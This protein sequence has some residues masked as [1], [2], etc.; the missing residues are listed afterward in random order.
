M[1]EGAAAKDAAVAKA[2]E[3]GAQRAEAAVAKAVDEAREEKTAAVAKVRC[4]ALPARSSQARVQAV[5]N[6]K[7]NGI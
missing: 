7:K 6:N 1:E 3:E 5:L 4:A 2:E